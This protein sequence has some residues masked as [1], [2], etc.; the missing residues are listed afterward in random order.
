M[1]SDL[2]QYGQPLRRFP[3]HWSA[4]ALA[5]GGAAVVQWAW[6]AIVRRPSFDSWWPFDAALIV[7]ATGYL[8]ALAE[9]HVRAA[10]WRPNELVPRLWLLGRVLVGNLVVAVYL[11]VIFLQGP[12]TS[13]LRAGLSILPPVLLAVCAASAAVMLLAMHD[14]RRRFQNDVPPPEAPHG[15]AKSEIVH[16]VFVIGLLLALVALESVEPQVKPWEMESHQPSNQPAL[17]NRQGL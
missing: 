12:Q 16:D 9:V 1:A 8:L 4:A 15:A 5:I 17:A 3:A 6:P 10:S 14:G 11:L 2:D 7:A 13:T